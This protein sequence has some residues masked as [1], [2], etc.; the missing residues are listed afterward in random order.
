[1]Q[2]PLAETTSPTNA[3]STA[4]P[5]GEESKAGR[6]RRPPWITI[7]ASLIG[8]AV[9]AVLVY[10]ITHQAPNRTLDEQLAKGIDPKAPMAHTLVPSLSGTSHTSLAA[11]RG[12]VVLLN[13]WASWCVGCQQEASLMERAERQLAPHDATVLGITYQDTTTDSLKFVKKYGLTFP[14][15]HDANGELVS[16]FGTRQLP[17]SFVINREGKIV[18]I[19]RG[20]I[21]PSFVKQAVAVAEQG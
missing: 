16:A 2:P 10:G 4:E 20:E 21:E 3:G 11:F 13:F 6:R 14:N 18:E 9:V 7:L 5:M 8:A 1:M 17:E 19:S 12:K 15:Y